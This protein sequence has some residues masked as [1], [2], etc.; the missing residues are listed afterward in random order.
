[1]QKINFITLLLVSFFIQPIFPSDLFE[2]Y[3]LDDYSHE[4]IHEKYPDLDI[5]FLEE[6]TLFLQLNQ[7]VLSAVLNDET[8][9]FE[10]N[11]PFFSN[12]FLS[13]QLEHFS[14]HPQEISVMR[15]TLDQKIIETYK[16]EI[17]TYKI[18]NNHDY[19]GVFIFSNKG[20]KAVFR[21]N[22]QI[23]QL[24]YF[25]HQ[26]SQHGDI[27]FVLNVQNSPVEFEFMCAHDLLEGDII[28][29]HSHMVSSPVK[30][31]DV[32]IDIDYYTFQ[33]FSTYQEA[34]D[35]SLEIISVASEI[36]AEDI[37]VGIKSSTA[38]VWEFEDPYASYIENP[39]DMLVALRE[40]WS[41]NASLTQIN[42]DLVHLF[43]KRT[44]TGTGGIAFLNGI[45]SDWNGYGFSSN[46]TDNTEYIDLPVPYFFWN[47][48]CF[49]HELG[50]N[51]G[52]KHTQWC[53]WDG[54]PIDNCTDI[55]EVVGGECGDYINN[56]QP[57]IGTIMSYCHTWSFEEG[58]GIMLKFHDIVKNTILAYIELQNIEPCNEIYV[59]GCMDF[60]ACNYN[61]QAIEDDDS[62]I[63][64][65]IGYDCFGECINDE[66][67]DGICDNE[68]LNFYEND[69]YSFD[70]YPNPASSYL[71]I[72][73]NSLIDQF[74]NLKLF[75]H[76][77]QLILSQN[78]VDDKSKIDLVHLPSGIYNA[79]LTTQS[80]IS[81]YNKILNKNIIIQ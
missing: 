41:T 72:K 1:M 63:Y 29:N 61:N 69:N 34:I 11:L 52:A 48:Y 4:I 51:F 76:L 15:H 35:W 70:I 28:S 40:N 81:G 45:G 24:D 53:G 60:D 73:I 65:E 6:K 79:Q 32:A 54:G 56:P 49:A 78:N 5:K 38:Q 36:F 20:V 58:G 66:N 77:G 27:Y 17:K 67:Q 33:T 39:Q 42:R 9:I 59:L 23:Y 46:L 75:N 68:S 13:F 37:N 64:P 55:E 71:K 8:S 19:K 50:H 18:I 16:P 47:I 80:E 2:N 21:S 12:Q 3:T 74:F 26:K 10:I 57:Q 31:V 30:C 22:D 25:N 44:D 7:D 43:S 62:C 14:V